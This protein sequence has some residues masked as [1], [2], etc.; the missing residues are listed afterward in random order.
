MARNAL[1]LGALSWQMGA[2]P[3]QP[4]GPRPADDRSTVTQWLPAR[5][6]GDVRADLIAAG[7]IPPVETP[8][9]I[10]ASAWVDDCDWW[11]RVQLPGSLAPDEVAILEADG[12]DYYSATWLDNRRLNTHAGMFSRQVS[13]IS[14]ELNEPGAHELAIRVWGGAALPK[15]SNPPWRQAARWLIAKTAPGAEYF[16]DRMMTP[17][18]QFSFGWDFSPRLLS[19][20]IWDD[21]RLVTCRSAY[22]ED[23]QVHPETLTGSDD[24]TPARWRVHLTGRTWQPGPLRVELEISDAG[25][26]GT[27]TWRFGPF[28][29]TPEP[30]DPTG[31]AARFSAA[32]SVET[33]RVRR[34]WPWDQGEPHCYRVTAHLLDRRG[35]RDELSCKSGVRSVL[36][37]RFDAGPA[38]RFDVNGRPTFLRGANWAPADVL[39][40][41]VTAADTA[42][43]LDMARAAGIN[44]L[45]IWGGGVREKRAFWETCNRLGIMTWQEF[46]LACA[47]LDHYPRDRAYLEALD[48]ESRGMIRAVRNHPSLIAWCGG[49]EFNI[50]RERLPLEVLSRAV[51]EED[52]TRPFI[53]ASPAPGSVHQWTVWHGYAPWATLADETAA[54]M[55]EFGM[56]ALPAAATLNE[57]FLG[58][59]PATLDDPRWAARKAQI[60]KLRHYAG[61]GAGRDLAAAIEA[62]QVAQAAALQ[63]GIEGCRLRRMP[64]GAT[65]AKLTV[66]NLRK[67]AQ[68]PV[69][70]REQRDPCSGV[71]FWQ[72]NEPWPAVSWAVIDRAGRP[73][74]AYEMLRRVFQPVLVAARFRWRRYR[75]GD[76]FTAEIWVV[77]DEPQDRTGC[78]IQAQLDGRVVWSQDEIDL[79]A[80]LARPVGTVSVRLDAKPAEFSLIL[81]QCGT[82]LA[83]NRYDLTVHLP[84]RP[85]LSAL[86]MRWLSG[87]LITSPA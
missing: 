85:P 59:A 17:K 86:F 35:I 25:D 56:Q 22:I 70:N 46:P 58:N 67:V 62:T 4:F 52:P 15:Q 49:N 30:L 41:R 64:G 47:F 19:A 65:V 3:R 45:R 27:E 48:Q 34:W 63:A 21:I 74:Q 39:P 73:K 42:R 13:C 37:E 24:P 33:A 5:V 16:P 40:G 29:I 54:L 75:A 10:A 28:E 71:A 11:Y 53:P 78:H 18:A 2:A 36:R 61:P 77:S 7:R 26:A 57:M 50:D 9:G 68:Q 72:F 87:Q 14:P 51:T 81:S 83:L 43:L 44:F 82:T 23:L 8:E 84:G 38:W 60:A 6:P 76:N 55:D 80:A 12:I 32:L 1:D 31:A 20:G 69:G 66:A 79:P